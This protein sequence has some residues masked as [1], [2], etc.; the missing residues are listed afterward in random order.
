MVRIGV[1]SS[2]GA[3]CV[4]VGRDLP[5]EYAQGIAEDRARLMGGSRLADP[6]AAWR[7]RPASAKQLD[8]LRRWGLLGGRVDLTAGEA[9]DLI[10]AG[11]RGA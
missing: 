5:L 9:S 2:T 4:E 3:A 8:V 10:S 1:R 11:R 6:H 7:R